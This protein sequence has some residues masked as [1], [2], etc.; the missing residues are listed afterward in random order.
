VLQRENVKHPPNKLRFLR[1]H[2]TPL[3]SAA[4]FLTK[5]R[6]SDNAGRIVILQNAAFARRAAAN[7]ETKQAPIEW[8]KVDGTRLLQNLEL[9]VCAL[10]YVLKK[11]AN[12]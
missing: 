2:K 8:A 1:F 12:D 5:T 7:I 11:L 3:R 10:F 9:F 4:A 6:E